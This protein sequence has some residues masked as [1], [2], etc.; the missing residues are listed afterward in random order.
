MSVAGVH[1]YSARFRMAALG[2]ITTHPDWRGQGLGTAATA[3]LCKNLL[4]TVD[5]V[6]LNV[7]SDNE[8]A[9]RMYEKLGFE[10]VAKYN[11]YMLEGRG[12]ILG[13]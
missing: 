7:S 6:G 4:K 5:T 13:D 3:G 1:V 10:A 11:E 2:N 9:I 12:V 8:T